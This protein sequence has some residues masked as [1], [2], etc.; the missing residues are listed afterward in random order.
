M[1]T[2]TDSYNRNALSWKLGPDPA[3]LHS[4]LKSA[5][6]I[7]TEEMLA[8]GQHVVFVKILQLGLWRFMNVQACQTAQL[9]Q[10]Y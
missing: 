4:H 1:F 7:R 10:T 5:K 9:L 6:G 2:T 8:L 3:T